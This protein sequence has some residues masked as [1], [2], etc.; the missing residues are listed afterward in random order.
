[1]AQLIIAAAGA[2]IGGALAPG[3]ILGGALFGIT[4][5]Q[6]GWMIGSVVGSMLGPRQNSQGPRLDDLKV[7]GTEYGQPIPWI[8]GA[9][10]IAGQIWW[11]SERRETATTEEV[12][13]KGGG[14]TLTTYS[15]D[16]DVLCGLADCEAAGVTR[17]WLNGKLVWTVLTDADQQSRIDS[18]NTSL[19]G[20][21]TFYG[22][23]ASQLP[24][25]VYEAA[26]GSDLAPG[27]RGRACIFV[28]GLQLGNSGQL[29]NLTFE[30]CTAVDT[31]PNISR[32]VAV[33]N[34]T[35]Q[36]ADLFDTS[37]G[38][39]AVLAM[40]P[41]VRVGVLS[42]TTVYE[43]D[44]DGVLTATTTRTSEENYP[45]GAGSN[46][47]GLL[48]Y[49]VGILGGEPVRAMN[50]GL[51]LNAA[52]YHLMAGW[53]T[54]GSVGIGFATSLTDGIDQTRFLG[55]VALCS[56][57]LHALIMTSPTTPTSGGSIIDR[58]HL[59]SFDGTTVTNISEGTIASPITIN[60]FGFGNS[61]TY[62]FGCCILEDDLLHLWWAYG[63]GDGNVSMYKIEDD[64]VLRL[65]SKLESG[66]GL[67]Q[68]SFTQPSIWAEAGYC[69]A[70]SRQSF[71]AFARSGSS[72]KV[73]PIEDAV[74][75]ICARAGLSASQYSTTELAA[76]DKSVRA[77][78]SAQSHSGRVLLEQLQAAYFFEASLSDKLYFRPRA[79]AAVAT[80]PFADLA[81]GNETAGEQPLP[82]TLSG[83]LELPAL[84]AVRYRNAYKDQETG[85][86][87]ADRITAS[88]SSLTTLDLALSLTP[89]EAKAVAQSA[90]A[91]SQAGSV[92]TEIALPLAYAHLEPADV[93]EVVDEDGES[94]F[95]LRLVRRTDEAGVLK[96]EAVVDDAQVVQATGATD[97]TDNSAT[98][99]RALAATDYYALDIPILRDAEDTPGYYVAARGSSVNWAGAQILSSINA[100]DYTLAAKVNESAVLGV[101]T[102]T[103]GDW[104][105]GLVMD[106]VNSVTVSLA[107]GELAST[108]RAALLASADSNTILIGNEV[109][110]FVT[111]ALQ[112]S[113]PNI[114]KLTRLLRGQR[115]TEWASTGHAGSER[116]VLLRPAGMRYVEQQASE[117]GQSRS[118]KG[119]SNG[120]LAADA[121][122][123]SFTNTGVAL[124]PFA[125]VDLRAT[126]S[127]AG[128]LTLTWTRRTRL[129]T[130]L[131]SAS[132]INAP[133]GESAEAY[134]VE[135]WNS[136]YTTLKR[137]I[138]GPSSAQA[139]Y[140]AAQ[141]FDDFGAIQTT[142]YCKV[143]QVSAAVGAGR[144]LV[145]SVSQALSTYFAPAETNDQ[146]S[147]TLGAGAMAIVQRRGASGGNPA[148][149]LYAFMVGSLPALSNFALDSASTPYLQG[150]FSMFAVD[151]T[152]GNAVLY[153]RA[154]TNPSG[155]R[156]LFAG[157]PGALVEVANGSPGF[158]PNDPP[159]GIAWTG[160]KF[161]LI[162]VSSHVYHSDDGVEWAPQ[163]PMSSGAPTFD[164]S[165]ASFNGAYMRMVAGVLVMRYGTDVYYNAAADGLSWAPCTGAVASLPLGTYTNGFQ[166]YSFETSDSGDV[167]VII[168]HGRTATNQL[169][170]VVYYTT[171]GIAWTE[172]FNAEVAG[173]AWG[174]RSTS[175][176]AGM[177]W[178]DDQFLTDLWPLTGG[179]TSEDVIS[180]GTAGG[181]AV[182]YNLRA[183][184]GV[185]TDTGLAAIGNGT[186]GFDAD[187]LHTS[188]DGLAWTAVD[189][190]D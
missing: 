157:T 35:I 29:P 85:T 174:G 81:A 99:V 116:A 32:E 119:V 144:P 44:I 141:Q 58:W 96:F 146:K 164:P 92:S 54:A 104:S 100:V 171:D 125:P 80:I 83:D 142:V 6:A 175:F 159:A 23:G 87:Y 53:K 21:V 16:I 94:T 98:T 165:P 166:L 73:V 105:A 82:L 46:G 168:G 38:I 106:E 34:T 41:A 49:P 109:V 55:Q 147:T 10:R 26:V 89:S 37:A 151:K 148:L 77:L 64:D 112:S 184:N 117:L 68:R 19:W 102:T 39:P 70:F 114:Y 160:T 149:G 137:T 69:V 188:T 189:W 170:G 169:G 139:S 121:T 124:L 72:P 9:P 97:N 113:N 5:A 65:R 57:G 162:T 143:R 90:S 48:S 118:L 123:T 132:G 25:A 36:F 129:S 62:H 45:D 43:F 2:A 110:R 153:L 120:A 173:P 122:A 154:Q 78:V 138:S 167:G 95:R 20:R 127:T 161:V 101:C 133:L 7:T 180:I 136:S 50:M 59:I 152:T 40:Q 1:M 84:V 131:I 91:D 179:S 186:I 155:L 108:T 31:S 51:A 52:P 42:G 187:T 183:A 88:Q 66:Q 27:Y 190:S 76:T 128:D 60:T 156:A 56:D 17:I 172:L 140:T 33:A 111:A 4:G 15:Y 71:Q 115:G 75:A 134:T 24:D 3:A 18:E 74:A 126:R 178:Y 61:T 185:A 176:N 163:G 79:A 11:A 135:I 130:R 181:D 158:M 182:K 103:L 28:Q 63:A 30:V 8:C 13:G 107:H 93:V 47:G 145:G 12:G 22:G 14:P 67:Q 86:E 150:Q 177:C